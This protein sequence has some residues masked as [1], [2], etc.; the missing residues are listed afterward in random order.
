MNIIFN[1]KKILVYSGSRA[2]YS[3][4]K[5]L[6]NFMRKK[7]NFKV[8]LAT[9]GIHNSKKFGHTFNEIYQDKIK[10]NYKSKIFLKKTNFE[11]IIKFLS[12]STYENYKILSKS[13]P[14]LV[15]LYGDRYEVLYFGLVAYICNIPIAHLH[16]GEIT[17]G[18]NDDGFRHALTKLSNYHFVSHKAYR[19]RVIQL[20]E[21]P[22][23]VFNF[24]SISSENL[25]KMK[26]ESKN[27]LFKKYKIPLNKKIALVTFHPITK[28]NM[29]IKNYINIFLSAINKFKNY[30][31]IIT[32][33]NSDNL[34]D[35]YI[36]QINKFKRENQNVKLFKFMGSK[37]Y[38]SFLKYSDIIIGNSSSGIYEAPALKTKT[39][40]IGNR[41][42]G[43]INSSS[44]TNVENNQKKILIAMNKI[45]KSNKKIYFEN[46]YFKKNTCK[47]INSQILKILKYKKHDKKFYDL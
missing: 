32:Y 4:L 34:G 3:N 5:I 20:G 35:Y 23:H 16:G 11:N 13:K 1:K 27:I 39:L 45:F 24:G 37:T 33:N 8:D 6:I 40:N 21:N 19:N 43:R 7:K 44:I 46:I 2:D 15:L 41:Q 47:N 26:F 31:Y 29:I 9:S 36:N 14:N 38:L 30:Y 10:I 12:S 25:K 28:N 18:A 42:H 22:K 17:E